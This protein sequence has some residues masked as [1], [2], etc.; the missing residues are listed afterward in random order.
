M[1]ILQ[2]SPYMTCNEV[3]LLN[4]CKSGFGYMVYDIAHC[5]TQ[6]A[7][8]D[9]LLLNYRYKGFK[10]GGINFMPATAFRFMKNILLCSNPFIPF[11]LLWKYRMRMRTFIRIVYYWIVT[12]Y[13][14][15]IIEKGDYDIV[16][17]HG[18][19]F[20]DELLMDV[21]HRAKQPFVITL[22]G[23]NSFSET[24]DLEPAGK[25]YER[26]FLKRVVDGEFHITVIST[27]IKKTILKEFGVDNCD[28][29]TVV[30]NAF[31]FSDK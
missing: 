13:Y 25:R 11:K 14:S 2:I 28:N 18:C 31:S 24:V 29:I 20:A 21:C 5:L 9:A 1:K 15:K 12:G 22:H 10:H 16:H 27:G 6:E 7:Q 17:I 19:I 4:Q 23:L 8:V 30:C 3:P 26:D